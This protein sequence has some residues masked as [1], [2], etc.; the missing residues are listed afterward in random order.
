LIP[1][2]LAATLALASPLSA[3]KSAALDSAL[4]AESR[5]GF[6]GVVLVA[7]G[8]SA[9]LVRAYG[10]AAR[11][12]V[13]PEDLAFWIASDSKQFT[14]TAILS[15]EA[16]GR[17]RTS[18]SLGRF[19]PR[20]PEDKRGI[21]IHQLLTHTSGL[22]SAYAAEGLADREAAVA[23]I[24]ALRLESKP[25]EKFS[26]SNDGYNL[27]SAIVEVASG[28]PFDRY[29]SDSVIARANLRHTGL[30]GHEPAGL[31]LAATPDPAR[32]KRQR[33]TIYRDGHSVANWGFRGSAGVYS[34]AADLHAW[35]RALQ[36]GQVLD[37][38]ALAK[39]VGHH[40]LLRSDANGES[41]TAYG[42]GVKVKDGRDLSYGHA[43][44]DD[45]LGQSSVIHWTPDG[46]CVVVL[47]NSGEIGGEGWASRANRAVRRVLDAAP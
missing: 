24:L 11:A 23:A 21:T 12:A 6:S 44:S 19:F 20:V 39:L 34:T 13:A 41:W 42:W 33:P 28:V 37:P 17:L 14:A 7:R 3:T 9:R 35:V 18:D 25:G 5:A 1:A 22:P 2:L 4:E 46:D 31:V 10:N 45:W 32:V 38:A 27:L 47:A 40:V 30:W 16:R 43:G 8:D 26:Y 29:L 36:A 15:L